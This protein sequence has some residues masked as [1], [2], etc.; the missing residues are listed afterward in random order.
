MEL[1]FSVDDRTK[2]LRLRVFPIPERIGWALDNQFAT[3]AKL[4]EGAIFLDD[5]EPATG[6]CNASAAR[7]ANLLKR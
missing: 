1:S 2:D 7:F 6:N 4:R 3:L 5:P